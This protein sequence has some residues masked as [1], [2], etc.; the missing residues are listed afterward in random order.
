LILPAGLAA[1]WT[2][3]ELLTIAHGPVGAGVV[4]TVGA[5][6]VVDAAWQTAARRRMMNLYSMMTM[7]D[8]PKSFGWCRKVF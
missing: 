7:L 5:V 3:D 1:F 8:Q 4:V 2:E 6:E